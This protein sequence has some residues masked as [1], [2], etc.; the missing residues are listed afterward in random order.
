MGTEACLQ[1]HE[2]TGAGQLL[3]VDP[4]VQAWQVMNL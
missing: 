3:A 2:R 4:P 1:S